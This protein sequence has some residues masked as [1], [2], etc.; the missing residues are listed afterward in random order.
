MSCARKGWLG[1]ARSVRCRA[2]G[3]RIGVAASRS[4]WL[5]ALSAL[6]FPIALIGVIGGLGALGINAFLPAIAIAIVAVHLP[7]G[8]LCCRI[9]PFVSRE[10]EPRAP[11]GRIK[12]AER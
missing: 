5:L 10:P 7:I 6:G 11:R 3:K 2:C 12:A 8:W 4:T 9:V 1:P